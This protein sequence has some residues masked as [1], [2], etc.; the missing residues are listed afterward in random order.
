MSLSYTVDVHCDRCYHWAGGVTGPKPEARKALAAAKKEGWSRNVR[1]TYTDLC[2]K[3]L[4]EVR[5][6]QPKGA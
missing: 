2:P 1:S 5:A 3:C 6:E 4:I